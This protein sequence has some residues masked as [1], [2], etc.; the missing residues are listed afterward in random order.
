[1]SNEKNPE[2]W[3][4]CMIYIY[5]IWDV[6]SQYCPTVIAYIVRFRESSNC[7]IN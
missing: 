6:F 1:M 4:Q 3:Q 5:N 7:K 2:G